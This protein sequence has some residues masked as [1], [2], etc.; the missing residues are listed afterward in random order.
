MNQYDERNCDAVYLSSLN[1]LDRG[2]TLSLNVPNE[3]GTKG[4]VTKALDSFPSPKI[5]EIPIV[6]NAVKKL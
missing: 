3:P 4:S 6:Y 1:V 5:T 2:G